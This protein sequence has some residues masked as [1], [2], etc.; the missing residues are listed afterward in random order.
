MKD[1]VILRLPVQRMVNEKILESNKKNKIES[2]IYNRAFG[3][4]NNFF[5]PELETAMMLGLNGLLGRLVIKIAEG[6]FKRELEFAKTKMKIAKVR[7]GKIVNIK[8]FSFIWRRY[9]NLMKNFY[10]SVASNQSLQHSQ[11]QR[12]MELLDRLVSLFGHLR[13]RTAN[14]NQRLF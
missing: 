6:V 5:Q 9:T 4:I 11:V 2:K 8:S 7:K 10:R 14:S 3:N 12:G 13:Y 1:F